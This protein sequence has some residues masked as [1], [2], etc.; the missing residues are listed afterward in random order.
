ME[1]FLNLFRENL[2]LYPEQYSQE[3]AEHSIT[4][5]VDTYYQD[6]ELHR[7]SEAKMIR[8]ARKVYMEEM[9]EG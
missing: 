6:D 1:E 4:C 9:Q 2:E 7:L 8:A 3:L 5:F